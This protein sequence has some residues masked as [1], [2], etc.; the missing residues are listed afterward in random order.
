M[1]FQQAIASCFTNYATFAGR[2]ARSE[3]WYWLLFTVIVSIVLGVVDV[4]IFGAPSPDS[5]GI[6]PLST[7]FSLGVL[8]PGIA[9]GVRRLH[10]VDRN[11]WWML[12][13]LTI[14]GIIPLIY[15]ICIKGTTGANRFGDDPLR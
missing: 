8:L 1:N 9:V 2:A 6:Q 11:G 15:W 12:I 7:L 5:P 10:D 13:P 4:L 14:I 3:Y